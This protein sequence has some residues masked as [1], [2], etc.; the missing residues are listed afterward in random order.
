MEYGNELFLFNKIEII[1]ILNQCLI[2]KRNF[3]HL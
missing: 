1:G 3:Y 2:R